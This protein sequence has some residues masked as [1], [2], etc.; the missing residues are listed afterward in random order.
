M[1]FIRPP[2]HGLHGDNEMSRAAYI[3]PPTPTVAPSIFD[4]WGCSAWSHFFGR[5]GE[6]GL[7]I[8]SRPGSDATTSPHV[9]KSIPSRFKELQGKVVVL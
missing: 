2:L 4:G 8:G 9:L 3:L 7:V 6:P 1:S 5:K